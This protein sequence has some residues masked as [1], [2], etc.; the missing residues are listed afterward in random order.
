MLPAA[1]R[2]VLLTIVVA[3]ATLGAATPAIPP[4]DDWPPLEPA[5]VMA[6]GFAPDGWEEF[7]W[8]DGAWEPTRRLKVEY[9]D[10][11]R[12]REERHESWFMEQWRVSQL[13]TLSYD[14][15][16][17]LEQKLRQESVGVTLQDRARYTYAHRDDAEIHETL[18]ARTPDGRWQP[19][20]LEIYRFDDAGRLVEHASHRR[21]GNLTRGVTLMLPRYDAAGRRAMLLRQ[22]DQGGRWVDAEKIEFG[23]MDDGRLETVALFVIGK[24]GPDWFEGVRLTHEFDE[25]GRRTITNRYTRGPTDGLEINS[26]ISHAYDEH[27]NESERVF[28]QLRDGAWVDMRKEIYTTRAV[29]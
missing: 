21:H 18:E 4:A 26:R 19:L 20:G 14:A 9:D 29:P 2:L 28:Q 10:Q 17:R 3:D 24:G 11:D 27:G 22:R 23:Y 1:H 16:G 15:D 8:R 5:R 13:D 12:R 7:Q 25:H 6:T